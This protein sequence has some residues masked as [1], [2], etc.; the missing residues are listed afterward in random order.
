MLYTE[1]YTIKTS[2]QHKRSTRLSI[3]TVRHIDKWRREKGL[4]LVMAKGAVSMGSITKLLGWSRKV[5]YWKLVKKCKR[6]DSLINY[7]FLSRYK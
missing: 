2:P 6:K 7:A 3:Y 1:M 4:K 5:G